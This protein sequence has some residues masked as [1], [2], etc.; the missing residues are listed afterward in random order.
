MAPLFNKLGRAASRVGRVLRPRP[1]HGMRHYLRKHSGHASL[2]A[3]GVAVGAASDLGISAI[4]GEEA[5]PP[6]YYMDGAEDSITTVNDDSWNLVSVR[7]ITDTFSENT[8]NSMGQ[9]EMDLK[10]ESPH[11]MFF[12]HLKV[13]FQVYL[14]LQSG[15]LILLLVTTRLSSHMVG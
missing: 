8:D 1:R 12:L 3:G 9:G 2:I 14:V 11:H 15:D 7:Q 4:R 6:A 10:K 13:A 5:A